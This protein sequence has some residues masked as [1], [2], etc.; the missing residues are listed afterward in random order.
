[1]CLCVWAAHLAHRKPWV[2]LTAQKLHV[3]VRA[4][5]PGTQ[6]AELGSSKAYLA[7]R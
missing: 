3:V 1:M 6:E 2:P 5:K 4:C 7:T